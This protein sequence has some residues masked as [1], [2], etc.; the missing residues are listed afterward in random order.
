MLLSE[1]IA[2]A[3]AGLESLYPRA[4]ARS[5]VSILVCERLG[6]QSWTHIANPSF[7]VPEQSLAQL[8]ADLQKLLASEPLQYVLGYAEFYGR[9]FRVTK[10][11]LIPRPETEL[12]VDT[13]LQKLKSASR[14]CDGDCGGASCG[15]DRDGACG[16]DCGGASR[17]C[18]RVSDRASSRAC[19]RVGDCGGALKILDLCTGSGCIAWTLALEYPQSTCHACS[20]EPVAACEPVGTSM[21]GRASEPV[22]ASVS[23][24]ASGPVGVQLT[25]IDIS[26]SALAIARS[27]FSG[28]LS[29]GASGSSQ[30]DFGVSQGAG[31]VSQGVA[32]GASGSSE[33]A[34]AVA[35]GASGN[36]M[37]SGREVTFIEADVLDLSEEGLSGT[38]SKLPLGQFDVIVSN[39]PY[40][41]EQEK[42]L[43]RPNVLD[44]E[45]ALALFVPD[46][47]PLIFYRAIAHHA[48]RLLSAHGWGIVEI[49]SLLAEPTAECFR[50]AG[51]QDVTILPDLSG[52]PRFVSFS[53][54]TP[55]LSR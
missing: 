28:E 40:V 51:L 20:R 43:M 4:E 3:L 47:D 27:Q 9:R 55:P 25:A 46:D 17:T 8:E 12:L 30:G 39:P 15:G 52:K 38:H 7:E 14:G 42:A 35:R 5:M 16:G 21:P 32:R 31:A 34:F 50:Q 36:S 22:S 23:G 2:S 6:V 53:A 11:V 54:G 18:E 29:R 48:S 13:V 45:P 24:R 37:V 1:F 33:N 44:H 10:D 49:N 19:E 41:M 26:P